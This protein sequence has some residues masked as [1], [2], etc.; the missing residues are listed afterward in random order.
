MPGKKSPGP[1]VKDK[2]LYEKLRDEGNSKS[3]AARIANAAAGS[4][5]RKVGAKGGTSP[6]YDDWKR[7]DLEKQAKKVGIKGRS[8]MKKSDLIKSLRH[9]S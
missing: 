3:K 4:S 6:S 8:K 2:K 7:A 1:S 5:R 9:H